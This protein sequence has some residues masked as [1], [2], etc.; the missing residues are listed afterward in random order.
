MKEYKS[1]QR[2]KSEY[3]EK[4]ILTAFK[5]PL[6]PLA[7]LV[8]ALGNPYLKILDFKTLCVANAPMR[9]RNHQNLVLPPLRPL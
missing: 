4:Y 2:K 3:Y 1:F 8:F 9:K 7:P 6:A 5:S